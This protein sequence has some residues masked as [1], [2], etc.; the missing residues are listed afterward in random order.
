M[1]DITRILSRYVCASR[2]G[3]LP[4]GVRH[5][6]LRAFVNFVGCAAGGAREED[7][8]LMLRFLGEF[9]GPTEATV[10]ARRERL[11]ILNA[12]FINSM[13]SSALAFND[14]HYT[15]VAH[16]TSPVAAALLA[17][18]ERQPLTG[19]DL[20][21]ALVLG[22]EIQCRVG[23]ILT[24]PPA[25][26]QVGLSM[27]GLVGTIGAAVAAGKILALDENG[28]ATAIGLAAN[29]SCG[30]RQAQST[31]GSHFTPG[32]AARGGLIAA[33]LAARGFTCSDA[34]IEGPKGFAVSYGQRPNLDA[35]VDEL[36]RAFEISTLSYKPYPSGFVIHPIIDAC[37]DIV[38]ANAFDA[39]QIER[40]ELTINPL[41]VKLTNLVDPGDRGQ[42]LV[43]FQHWAVVTL[44]HRA[45]GIAQVA[46][47]VVRDPE[48]GALRR[49][50]VFTSL[51]SM[52]VE[53]AHVRVIL[54]DGRKLEAAV[55]HC[56]GSVERPMTDE[57]ITDK[58]RA[59]LQSAYTDAAAE[60]I[61][62]RAWQIE[63]CPRVDGFCSELAA[64]K[65]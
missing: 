13:S 20:L 52:R 41:T 57:D 51:D 12:A 49:R 18:A 58:T 5:E 14:T 22:V 56:R 25:Q 32:N 40:I 62:A 55:S 19:R 34:M 61:L 65:P 45:A 7:I 31:M 8:E 23:N 64:G 36:G 1:K 29:Q 10:V 44:V 46:D 38:R 35:A 17:L 48:V 24:T 27:Q 43:S 42:A 53:A 30:L 60:R 59:Q 4:P 50:V 16:P 28:M 21:H 11:D 39:T 33:L 54:K 15:S 9:S 47:A 6:G 26:C 63:E 2:F 3:D 37:L